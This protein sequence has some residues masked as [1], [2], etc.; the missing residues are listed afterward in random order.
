MKVTAII[1]DELIE[2][3]MAKTKGKNITE[4]LKTALTEWLRMQ[5]IKD[6]NRQVAESP[7]DFKYGAEELRE[8]NRK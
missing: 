4:S 6:L 8:L 2:E 5:R 7:L 1:Q 3:V